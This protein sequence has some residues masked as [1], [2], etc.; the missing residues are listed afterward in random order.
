M[1]VQEDSQSST[2]YFAPYQ[3]CFPAIIIPITISLSCRPRRT[4]SQCSNLFYLCHIQVLPA[5][6]DQYI[7]IQTLSFVLNQYK[8]TVSKGCCRIKTSGL[9]LTNLTNSHILP[10]LL[11]WL[12]ISHIKSRL[13]LQEKENPVDLPKKIYP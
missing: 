11:V 4:S 12:K 1:S 9:K 8:D 13:T 2:P 6:Q 10:L 3:W 7:N 5:Q